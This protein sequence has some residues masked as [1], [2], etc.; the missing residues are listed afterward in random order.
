M[1]F[2]SLRNTNHGKKYQELRDELKKIK[3]HESAWEKH[4]PFLTSRVYIVTSLLSWTTNRLHQLLPTPGRRGRYRCGRKAAPGQSH[5]K[6]NI[7]TRVN[8]SRSSRKPQEASVK[9]KRKRR[10]GV[11]DHFST[12]WR[13]RR[14]TNLRSTTA[15]QAESCR[16]PWTSRG[17]ANERGTSTR[18][19]SPSCPRWCDRPVRECRDSNLKMEENEGIVDLRCKMTSNSSSSHP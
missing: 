15:S 12:K 11:W 4:A 10:R 2:S 13:S 6:Q 18:R 7:I 14:S 19:N 3:N 17:R 16:C 8:N 9:E 5:L 1:A